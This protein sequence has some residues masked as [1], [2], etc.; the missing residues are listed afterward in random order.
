M[1]SEYGDELMHRKLAGLF[2]LEKTGCTNDKTE[3]R[4]VIIEGRI[5]S[6]ARWITCIGQHIPSKLANFLR[7]FLQSMT[8]TTNLN[9]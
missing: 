6:Q 3:T 5:A 8:L 4:D 2:I 9:P 7:K 1:Y